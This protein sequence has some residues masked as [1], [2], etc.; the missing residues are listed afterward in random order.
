MQWLQKQFIIF[1]IIGFSILLGGCL[2][3]DST[4]DTV[5]LFVNL[6]DTLIIPN[7]QTL[8]Q[9]AAEFA[10]DSGALSA[11]CAAI[12]GTEQT[13]A[14]TAAQ[15]AWRS[16]ITAWQR[17]EPHLLEPVIA[18]NTALTARIL[19]FSSGVLSTCGVDQAVVLAQNNDFDIN[20]R[21]L[22]QRGL[23]AVEYALFN[24]DLNHTCPSQIVETVDWNDLPESQRELQ[25]CEY[26]ANV[27]QDISSAATELLT[28][29]QQTFRS[30]FINPNNST[31][32]LNALSDALLILDTGV[33]DQKLGI[34]LGINAACSQTACAEQVE[35]RY[36]RHSLA[37]IRANLL[38][39]RDV[40]NGTNEFSNGFGFDDLL[41]SNGFAEVAADFNNQIDATLAWLDS[42][43]ADLFDQASAIQSAA[44]VDQ[45]I[46]A[47]ANP[48]APSDFPACNLYGLIKRITDDL[49]T[50]F[51]TIINV[52]LPDRAQ[53]DND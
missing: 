18:D 28:I 29:W 16:L 10:S 8:A 4:D 11:Y 26:A 33:K 47:V 30:Q 2:V 40:F 43:D 9:S 36:S 53:S 44:D 3:D 17:T 34:P 48:A 42:I 14:K 50:E 21:A 51:V 27:A 6:A 41:N 20:T 52:S 19:S 1:T 39:F 12:G 24:T 13:T 22:N 37:N 31:D 23:G 38:G 7:Y 46:N 45:C 5:G 15:A 49:K 32:N 25:R 35:S